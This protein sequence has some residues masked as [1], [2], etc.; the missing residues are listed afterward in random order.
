MNMDEIM[1]Q[2]LWRRNRNTL[3]YA[4]NVSSGSKCRYEWL[5]MQCLATTHC[6]HII[7]RIVT[8]AVS[9]QKPHNV[10]TLYR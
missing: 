10:Q 8:Y 3:L 9:A 2:K 6:Q 5:L 7:E 4:S 1:S